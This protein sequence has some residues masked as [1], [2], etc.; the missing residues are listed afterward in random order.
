MTKQEK[1]QLN[2]QIGRIWME[3]RALR[4]TERKN[5]RTGRDWANIQAKHRAFIDSNEE[6]TQAMLAKYPGK[7]EEIKDL[8]YTSDIEKTINCINT[9]QPSDG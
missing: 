5:I 3:L 1:V 9:I 7:L 6:L 8:R 4:N 2:Q